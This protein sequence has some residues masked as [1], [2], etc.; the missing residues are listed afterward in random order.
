M[1][2]QVLL[3]DITKVLHPKRIRTQMEIRKLLPAQYYN[4]LS[5]FEGNIAAE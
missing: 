2:F 1:I 3:E 5:L 4:H